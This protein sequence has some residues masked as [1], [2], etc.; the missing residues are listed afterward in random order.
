MA[1]F[2]VD[3]VLSFMRKTIIFIMCCVS[4]GCNVQHLL[5][6]SSQIKYVR[7]SASCAN[8]YSISSLQSLHSSDGCLLSTCACQV[9]F[10]SSGH[11][12]SRHTYSQTFQFETAFFRSPFP[13]IPV[14][15]RRQCLPF[16]K[17]KFAEIYSGNHALLCAECLSFIVDSHASSR[18]KTRDRVVSQ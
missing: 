17:S 1:A 15:I 16:D 11:V 10:H 12:V 4:S 3:A 13:S 6:G 8:I 18:S 5:A 7:Q 9:F 2:S 14:W